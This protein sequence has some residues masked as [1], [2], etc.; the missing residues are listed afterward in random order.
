MSTSKPIVLFPF[1]LVFYEI[2]TYLSNDMYLPALP[3]ILQD[4]QLTPQQA[5]LT[6][7]TWFLGSATMPLV[8]GPL[9]DR[10]GRRSILL[11]G[12]FIY[13]LTALFCGLTSNGFLLLIARALQGAM[14]PTM[15]VAGYACIHESYQQRDAIRI[16]AVM[17]SITILA[18]ALGPLFGGFVLYFSNWRSIFFIIAAW[19]SIG[20]CLL[21]YF[22]P[23]T[24]TQQNRKSLHLPSLIKTYWSIL[25]NQRFMLRMCLLGFIFSGF[26]AWFS[27][28]PLLIIENLGY[29]AM[30]FGWLQ[31][32]IFAAYI[33]GMH[34]VKAMLEKF[35]LTR[36]VQFGLWLVLGGGLLISMMAMLFPQSLTAFIVS[37]TIY[38]FGFALC[39][40][41][42][43]RLIIEAS[44][45]PMGAR[46]AIFAI[47]FGLFGSLGSGIAGLFFNGTIL[48]LAM[49]ITITTLIAT[50]ISV[51]SKKN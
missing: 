42:L 43:N 26:I 6:L 44:D 19:A 36:L 51:I 46:M 18:P 33:T 14:V 2:A 20:L 8:I 5:Q 22:M 31:V 39:F 12:G 23:E 13:V 48:S 27:A 25:T 30:V 1:L 3:E 37:M 38:A 50:G 11:V 4:L 28:G 9:S 49:I 45:E 41:P 21:Y 17:G 40:V 24:V 34:S 10:F 35:A 29:N 15:L 7:T 16:L 47:L 32:I